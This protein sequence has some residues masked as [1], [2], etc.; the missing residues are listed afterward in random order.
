MRSERG[1]TGMRL[2]IGMTL[3]AA[4]AWVIPMAFLGREQARQVAVVVGASEDDRRT[5]GSAGAAAGAIDR[6]ADVQAQARLNEAIGAAQVYFAENGTYEGFGP[7]VA[8][9]YA[10]NVRFTATSTAIG[11][12]SIRGVTP[13]S[14]VLV[15][16][17]AAGAHLC[18]AAQADVFSFG[19]SNAQTPA[20]CVGGWE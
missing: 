19:R 3:L 5:E 14:V 20:E 16:A 6:A 13:A 10:P 18:A 12:V 17:S 1:E 9:G 2:I 11:V 8:A 15:T 7:S 4:L